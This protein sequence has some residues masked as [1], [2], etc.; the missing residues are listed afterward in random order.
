MSALW[1]PF[2]GINRIKLD[3]LLLLLLYY[4]YYYCY[5]CYYHYLEFYIAP[6]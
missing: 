5:Y 4:H 6:N 3:G 1:Q 2:G